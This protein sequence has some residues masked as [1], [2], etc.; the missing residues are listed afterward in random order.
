MSSMDAAEVDYQITLPIP[1]Y[2]TFEDI[3]SCGN[4]RIIPFTGVDFSREETNKEFGDRIQTQ[5]E[6]DVTNGAK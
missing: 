3:Q 2:L 6:N 1:P 4:K 5:L